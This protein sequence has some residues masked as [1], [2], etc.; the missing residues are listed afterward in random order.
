[1]LQHTVCKLINTAENGPE[2]SWPPA[3]SVPLS[4]TLSRLPKYMYNPGQIA[5]SSRRQETGRTSW[6][7]DA[8]TNAHAV[9]SCSQ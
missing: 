8:G 1:M 6:H 2:I 3:V 7:A 9:I 5:G 4:Q